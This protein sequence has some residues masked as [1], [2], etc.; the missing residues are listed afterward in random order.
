ML[1]GW[2]VRGLSH[3]R[4]FMIIHQN[5]SE[6]MLTFRMLNILGEIVYEEK[7]RAFSPNE[8]DR[9]DLQLALEGIYFMQIDDGS[10]VWMLKFILLKK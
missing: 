1:Y 5:N 9:I 8:E 7:E 3:N 2:M 6:E 10:A 4:G